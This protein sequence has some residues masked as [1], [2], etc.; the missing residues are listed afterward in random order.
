VFALGERIKALSRKKGTRSVALQVHS[1]PFLEQ[2][3]SADLFE[4]RE[5][6]GRLGEKLNARVLRGD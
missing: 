3:S 2:E 4:K 6:P 1:T 5:K